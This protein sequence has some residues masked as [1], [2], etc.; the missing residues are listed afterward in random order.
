[1]RSLAVRLGCALVLGTSV[2]GPPAPAALALRETWTGYF[3][4]RAA[5]FH[6]EGGAPEAGPG[7]L[8]WSLAVQDRVVARGDVA[9]PAGREA[10]FTVSLPPVKEG[11]VLDAHLVIAAGAESRRYLLRLFPEDAWAARQVAVQELT[12]QLFDPVGTTA[13]V[14]AEAGLPFSL[15]ANQ[16]AIAQPAAALLVIGEGVSLS[17]APGL[18]ATLWRAAAAGRSVLCLAPGDGGF[19]LPLDTE[20]AG[21]R[22]DRLAW[23]GADVIRSLDKRIDATAWP[24]A[25]RLPARSFVLKSERQQ[26]V[27]ELGPAGA[28][29]PWID[30]TFTG[31]G[32]IV[33]CGWTV[34]QAWDTG[35]APRH[36]LVRMLEHLAA[37]TE[38]ESEP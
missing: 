35:P 5:T 18:A 25:G 33:F 15:V 37:K 6:V 20:P 13:A 34:I 24:P 26:V 27:V 21:V 31:G 23:R 14:L 22:P 36:L 32:R 28:G 9:W 1:M 4:G 3:G 11:V 17:R 30:A 29:W 10:V 38:K 7:S 8:G 16:E 2:Y 12:V 19:A